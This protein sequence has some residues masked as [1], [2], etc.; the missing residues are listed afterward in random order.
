M[1]SLVKSVFFSKYV[2]KHQAPFITLFLSNSNNTF[3]KVLLCR[4]EDETCRSEN[5]KCR[6]VAVLVHLP[7]DYE[8]VTVTLLQDRIPWLLSLRDHICQSV[9]TMFFCLPSSLCEYV[10][11]VLVTQYTAACKTTWSTQPTFSINL[12][13]NCRI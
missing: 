6:S 2:C 13:G 8:C 10:I 1:F 11:T 3:Q 7:L 4:N 9:S 12:C 5:E